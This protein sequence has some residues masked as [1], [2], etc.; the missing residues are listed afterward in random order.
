MRRRRV[1]ATSRRDG[2]ATPVTIAKPQT[3]RT[4]T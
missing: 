2:L 1:A 4:L 3:E